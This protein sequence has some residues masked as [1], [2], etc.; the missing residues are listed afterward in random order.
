M[1]LGGTRLGWGDTGTV[2]SVLGEFIFTGIRFILL[3][4]GVLGLLQASKVFRVILLGCAALLWAFFFSSEVGVA[5]ISVI[6][7]GVGGRLPAAG[8][9]LSIG[10]DGLG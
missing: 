1:L 6:P 7:T 9:L 2:C 5:G 8:C 10:V 3:G 4:L